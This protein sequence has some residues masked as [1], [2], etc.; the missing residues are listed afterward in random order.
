MQV[1][2]MHVKQ[3]FYART[4]LIAYTVKVAEQNGITTILGKVEKI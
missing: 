4:I 3:E 1:S 2:V